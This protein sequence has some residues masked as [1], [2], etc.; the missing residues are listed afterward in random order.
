MPPSPVHCAVLTE[1]RG[2]ETHKIALSG[3]EDVKMEL[4]EEETC[5]SALFQRR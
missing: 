1:E 4:K 2:K 3:N 5:I